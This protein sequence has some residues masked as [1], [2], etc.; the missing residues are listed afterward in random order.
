M[1]IYYIAGLPVA[2]ALTLGFAFAASPVAEASPRFTVGN[3]TDK[4]LSVEIYNGD[5][6]VC[7]QSSK[8][9]QLAPQ[10]TDT[11][12]CDGNGKGRCKIEIFKGG[13]RICNA[14]ENTC[15]TAIKMQDDSILY[16]FKTENGFE[17]AFD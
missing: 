17:C 1:R 16:I 3:K 15:N 12:G 5:D 10:E 13:K 14:L 2:A 4:S 11:Y 7:M 9:K 6:S 8:T